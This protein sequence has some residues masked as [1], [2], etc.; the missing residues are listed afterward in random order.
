MATDKV[1]MVA[2]EPS[3]KITMADLADWW[4]DI[5]IS[6]GVEIR[7]SWSMSGTDQLAHWRFT[8]RVWKGS[9][10]RAVEPYLEKSLVWPTASH[11]TVLGAMLWLMM[12][13]DD[14]LSASEAL[15]R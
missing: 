14:E 4:K 1:N 11:K 3:S 12:G 10:D 5:T 9:Y 13:I 15:T 7:S 8:V 2:R 6:H